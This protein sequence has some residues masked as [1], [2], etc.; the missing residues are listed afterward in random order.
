[1][2]NAPIDALESPADIRAAIVS[3]LKGFSI[4]VTSSAKAEDVFAHTRPETKVYIAH[5]AGKEFVA[6]I[7]LAQALAKRGYR[8]VPHIA[9]RNFTS[10]HDLDEAL[11]RLVADAGVNEI[12]LIAGAAA[13]PAGE[14][15][16]TIQ[17]LKSGIVTRRGIRKIGVAGHPEGHP[18]VSEAAIHQSLGWKNHF[19]E[20]QGIDMYLMTQMCFDAGRIIGW[21][22]T[23]RAIGI[24]LPV[25]VGLPG[26]AT[27]GT[28]AK[29]AKICGL[30]PSAGFVMRQAKNVMK[31]LTLSMPDITIAEL[32]KARTSNAALGIDSVHFYTLGNL[33]QT[34]AWVYAA[35]AGNLRLKPATGGF[36]SSELG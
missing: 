21:I 2:S 12:L 29:Y 35:S 19:A 23:I 10:Q 8:P 36:V 17:V 6:T 24:D 7:R 5:I 22:R 13:T 30:G 25:R 16:D 34:T 33:G 9:T 27:I 1:M 28:L 11:A 31:L 4:E 26:L 14:I 15:K 32:A 20:A 18:I 3:L